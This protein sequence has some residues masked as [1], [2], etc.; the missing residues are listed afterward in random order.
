M[1]RAS[2]LAVTVFVCGV[3]ACS[4]SKMEV[5]AAQHS[6]YDA[7]FNAVYT[8][9]LDA[10]R[11]LYPNLDD[12]PGTGKITTAW[13]QVQYAS[14]ADDATGVTA[15]PSQIAQQGGNSS[16]SPGMGSV[17]AGGAGGA[18]GM[19]QRLAYK[20]YYIRF[21][22]AVLGGRPWRVKVIGHAASWDVGA[23]LPTELH[24]AA[25]PPWLTP[26]VEALE[27]EIYRKM[28]QYALAANDEG[29]GAAAEDE[30]PKTDPASFKDV[31][32][33]AARALAALKDVLTKRDIDSLRGDIADDVVWSLGGAPGIDIAM[34]TWQ[35]DPDTF[36]QMA[37]LIDSGCTATGA[38]KVTCPG[39][40][41][42]SGQY[43]LVIE[44]RAG[45]WKVTSFVKGE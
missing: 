19:G 21:E 1:L 18:A 9:T 29:S 36:D 30:M 10:I 22:V 44:P 23:A 43:Q 31:P 4:A 39:G 32:A 6:L 26:R 41:L 2:L 35:A 20:K 37:K 7:D 25:R 15:T 16:M 11:S 28:K 42:Q 8:A 45:A 33:D 14:S 34:A 24:G 13:H 5:H 17:P 12:N 27:V 40:D 38:K 3:S